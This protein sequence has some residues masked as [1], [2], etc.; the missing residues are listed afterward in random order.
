M[1]SEAGIRLEGSPAE[2]TL[3]SEAGNVVTRLFCGACGSP[4]FGKNSGM[5]GVMTVSLGTLDQTGGLT[6]QV[7]IFTRTRRSWDQPDPAVQSYAAQ[8][9]WSPDDGL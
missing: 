6:P 1:Y 5:P 3:Q 8:P 4:L 7:E 2:Y 9:G